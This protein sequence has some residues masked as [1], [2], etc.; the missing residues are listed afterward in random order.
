MLDYNPVIFISIKYKATKIT[1]IEIT[2]KIRNLGILNK[3]RIGVR[4][5]KIKPIKLLI[6]NLGYRRMFVQKLFINK[7]LF[8]TNLLFYINLN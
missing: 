4:I 3:F 7:I 8:V 2:K 1:I 5:T 6:K